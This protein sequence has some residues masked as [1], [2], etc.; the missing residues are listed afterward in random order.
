MLDFPS[1]ARFSQVPLSDKNTARRQIA[2]ENFTHRSV[3]FRKLDDEQEEYGHYD[4]PYENLKGADE[5][6][7]CCRIVDEQDGEAIQNG[8]GA[9]GK[10]RD[11]GV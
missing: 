7:S 4:H 3:D 1:D 11:F 10:K 8:K 5:V 2:L 9:T 6:E